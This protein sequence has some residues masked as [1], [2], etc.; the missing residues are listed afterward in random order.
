MFYHL[1]YEDA[2]FFCKKLHFDRILSSVILKKTPGKA[3][4]F[5]NEPLNTFF[6]FTV[7]QCS[8]GAEEKKR[9]DKRGFKKGILPCC[10]KW[11]GCNIPERGF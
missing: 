8:T 3:I 10:L 9:K 4:P 6:D 11:G 7:L 1:V 5:L 2:V